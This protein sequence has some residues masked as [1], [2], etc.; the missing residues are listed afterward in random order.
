MRVYLALIT[1]AVALG[2]AW[3]FG[4]RS[5]VRRWL[6]YARVRTRLAILV[7]SDPQVRG[8]VISEADKRWIGSGAEHAIEL[9][10]RACERFAERPCMA[11]RDH[12]TTFAELWQ[13]VQALATGLQ[14]EGHVGR[15]EMVGI[16][17]FCSV[18]W[19]VA[20]LA[21]L[22]LGAVSVP[23]SATC[24]EK[25]LRHVLEETGLGVLFC[26]QE[27]LSRLSA[28]LGEVKVIA[29]E[30]SEPSDGLT[31]A[32]LELPGEPVHPVSPQPDELYS[33]VYTSGSTGRPKGVMMPHHRWSKT[34]QDALATKSMPRIT[35]AYLPLCHMAGRIN[36]YKVLMTGGLSYLLSKSDMSTLFE[37]L[38][39]A[40][41]THL[42]LVPRVSQ[43]LY[44]KFQSDFVSRGGDATISIERMLKS[45]LGRSLAKEMREGLMGG[46]L[47]FVHTGAA[48]TAPGV[49]HFLKHC[50]QIHVTDV[51]GSTE[52]GP[53]MVN[54]RVHPWLT[55]KLVDRPEL[56][57]TRQDHPFP[58]GELAIKS[59]RG[60]PGY[61]RNEEASGQL[62]DSEG[63][64]LSGDIV[65]E[66]GPGRLVWLDRGK[67]VLRLGHGEFVNVSKL[68]QLFPSKSPFI[69]QI[70]LY[71]NPHQ[72]CLLAVIVP[73]QAAQDSPQLKTLM[74]K[75]LLRVGQLCELAAHEL[76]RDFVL[77]PEPFTEANGLLSAA[78]KPRRPKLKQKYQAQLETLYQSI[79]ERQLGQLG[80]HSSLEDKL[81]AAMAHILGLAIEEV[82]SGSHFLGLG[83]DS[84]AGARLSQVLEQQYKLELPVSSLLDTTIGELASQL[85]P[86]EPTV[87]QVIHGEDEWVRAAQLD[88]ARFLDPTLLEPV[89]SSAQVTE[90]F[91]VTG[92]NGFLGRS[93]CLEL[94]GQGKRVVGLVRAD[95]D[96]SAQARMDAAYLDQRA[97]ACFA[98][99]A[100]QGQVEIVAGDLRRPQL[101]LS[102][103]LY[104]RLSNQV[105]AVFHAAALVNHSLDYRD[106]FDPNVAGTARVIRFA[107]EGRAKPIHYISTVGLAARVRQK[108][109]VSEEQS[110][111]ELWS[112]RPRSSESYASGYVTTKWA[113]EIL[114][115]ALHDKTGV[116][117]SLYRCAMLLPHSEYSREYNADDL[118]SRLFY[119]MLRTGLAPKSFYRGGYAARHYDGLP[120]DLVSRFLALSAAKPMSGRR[121]FHLSNSN[122]SDG[123]SLDSFLDWA[124]QDIALKRL[125]YGNFYQ[126]FEAALKSLPPAQRQRSPLAVL[127]RWQKPIRSGKEQ[128]RVDTTAFQAEF[129]RL[130]L[131]AGIPS[132]D[133][134]YGRRVLK[135]IG[136]SQ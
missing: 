56:G 88:L 101:G 76:P 104:R 59:P 21:C 115:E 74:R 114:L 136:E 67:N 122:W 103:S 85:S 8:A 126:S 113:S 119:G 66:R 118:F 3:L 130:G 99:F 19:A 123:V 25:E 45:S 34:F 16:C 100:D 7:Q 97:Q 1:L 48:P 135:V 80:S 71:G 51:Y 84:L 79:Q 54:G 12:S 2:A 70:Y 26:A 40:R 42:I 13:R 110:A 60:T 90:Q 73:T 117:V 29:I 23:L 20:D 105:G 30:V 120:V 93:L 55:Y 131:G 86:G 22:Y 53:V 37:D 127:D 111:S 24:T 129:A 5:Q 61:Y 83:G 65:E 14:R 43:L 57:F 35:L 4:R 107:L 87:Y 11:T 63:Y 133:E 9:L 77:E 95:S 38:S 62:R 94:L 124:P 36:L 68:E 39:R 32:D 125:G 6:V 109:M 28:A 52:I 106:L 89:V 41:P 82:H 17:G 75:E 27:Q 102:E 18:D 78:N 15:G 98:Q 10:G 33:I 44:Q 112:R 128:L 64:I 81:R 31:I 96:Q 121:I 69:E 134:E 50:F 132:L 108:G 49:R 58:R 92:A 116:P 46:R 91:L 47:C 72:A